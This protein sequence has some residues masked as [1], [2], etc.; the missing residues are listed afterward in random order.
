M[1]NVLKYIKYIDLSLEVGT[2]GVPD[3]GRFYI[4]RS[5]EILTSAP[6]EGTGYVFLEMT[7]EEILEANPQIK[8]P[9]LLIAQERQTREIMSA[10][11]ESAG[12]GRAKA[13]AKGGK[14]GRSGV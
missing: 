2:E 14:G 5:G 4:V 3:D 7:E 10:R 13:T 6:T 9:R 12:I 8:N 1:G 11:A